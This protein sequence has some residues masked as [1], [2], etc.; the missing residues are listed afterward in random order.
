LFEGAFDNYKML[1]QTISV[2]DRRTVVAVGLL[3][4][5]AATASV[6]S[7][8]N[9]PSPTRG[10]SSPIAEANQAA[11]KDDEEEE[12]AGEIA[13]DGLEWIKHISIFKIVNGVRVVDWKAFMRKFGLGVMNLGWT[14]AGS[15]VVFLTLSGTLQTIAGVSSLMAFAFAMYLHMKEPD[16]E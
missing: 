15:L 6:P 5:T 1:G 11:R 12:P 8:Q 14:L 10:S 13:G 16:G 3:T 9:L 2:G 7:S 4:A